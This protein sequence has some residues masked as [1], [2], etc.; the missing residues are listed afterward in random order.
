MKASLLFL[1]KWVAWER[2]LDNRAVA[3]ADAFDAAYKLSMGD[4]EVCDL[5]AI[6]N[7]IAQ[8]LEKMAVNVYCGGGGG[9]GCGCGCGGSSGYPGD[10]SSDFPPGGDPPLPGS[11]PG[12]VT[13]QELCERAWDVTARFVQFFQRAKMRNNGSPLSQQAVSSILY[14]LL[15]YLGYGSGVA[16][17]TLAMANYWAS[18]VVDSCI[19]MFQEIRVALVNAIRSTQSPV[20]AYQACKQIVSASGYGVFTRLVG[21]ALLFVADWDKVYS[22]EGWTHPSYDECDGTPDPEVCWLP[23]GYHLEPVELELVTS[24]TYTISEDIQ[25][26][27]SDP[28]GTLTI[29]DVSSQFTGTSQNWEPIYS[30]VSDGVPSAVGVAIWAEINQGYGGNSPSEPVCGVAI[31]DDEPLP[32]DGR[33]DQPAGYKFIACYGDDFAALSVVADESLAMPGGF[34]FGTDSY[35]FGLYRRCGVSGTPGGV[36]RVKLRIG[37]IVPD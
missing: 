3:M 4:C 13:A 28:C 6:R 27:A 37:V 14:E 11:E 18:G 33:F 1:G 35:H 34:N 22:V 31:S 16:A 9:G 26:G 23:P 21:W 15:I 2:T 25:V 10:T 7:I 8:E 20:E 29:L 36:N 30:F 12:T 5:D 32:T 24:S 17:L 19:A